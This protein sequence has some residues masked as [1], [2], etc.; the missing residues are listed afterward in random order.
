MANPVLM[1]L[2]GLKEREAV[3]DQTEIMVDLVL[4]EAKEILDLM[5]ERAS[6]ENLDLLGQQLWQ[7]KVMLECQNVPSPTIEIAC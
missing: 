7:K 4:R 6:P 2:W 1:G 3:M 5:E